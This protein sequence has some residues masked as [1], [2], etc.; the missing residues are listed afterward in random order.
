MDSNLQYPAVKEK[1]VP[2]CEQF[3]AG[4]SQECGDREIE[5]FASKGNHSCSAPELNVP[6]GR[7]SPMRGRLGNKLMTARKGP[8]ENSNRIKKPGFGRR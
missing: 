7:L 3:K 6:L 1:F 8:G 4:Y 5:E 2:R